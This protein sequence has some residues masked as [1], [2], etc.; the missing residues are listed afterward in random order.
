MLDDVRTF[1]RKCE[2]CLRFKTKPDKEELNP[3][4]VLYPLELVHLDYLTIGEKGTD[5]T[6][7]VLII[8]DHFTKYAQ[9][10]ITPKQT[11][12]VTAKVFWEQFLVH[13]G[14]PAKIISDQG[15]SFENKLF[16]ELCNIAQVQKLW[17]S[18]YHPET[19]GSCERFNSTLISMLG[20]LSKEEKLRW[21]KWVPAMTHAY[22]C[23]K[24]QVTGFS[25]YFLMFRHQPLLPIDIEYG[26]MAPYISAK[27]HRSFMKRL[28][29]RLRW[30]YK[31]ASDTMSKEAMHHKAYYD[32][33]M[34]CMTL[35]W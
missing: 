35:C 17:T 34:H 26:V 24:C 7:N 8:T 11:A 10:F 12:H 27:D 16:K 14:W 30:A 18:P 32:K 2:C 13:Y 6:V 23:T 19:N 31:I 4:E 29:K 5:K 9:A 1:T 22:N 3:I 25:P 15:R 20:T 28:Q 33:K 21:S